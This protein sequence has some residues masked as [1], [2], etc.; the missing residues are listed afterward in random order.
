[1]L[2][3]LRRFDLRRIPQ[4]G[5]LAGVDE[6]GRVALAGP[7]V[8]ACVFVEREELGR[9]EFSR[10]WAGVNDSKQLTAAR[11]ETL[12]RLVE[13][14]RE[15]GRLIGASGSASVAEIEARNI[16]GATRMAMRRALEAACPERWALPVP[17]TGGLFAGLETISGGRILIDGKPL[18]PFPYEHD[19]V[20]K[21]DGKSF[22]IALASILAKVT[23]DHL[24]EDLDQ[25]YPQYGFREHKGY[26]T[27]AHRAAI[28]EHGPSPVH[29][30]LFLRKLM[31][32]VP[33]GKPETDD[34]FAEA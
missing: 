31:A 30:P 14:E 22:A 15:A 13:A 11:R 10:R 9:A 20:V 19:A 25:L 4:G 2:E 18:R 6:A 1:M 24:M 21:G 17:E 3:S 23:R 26:G 32:S 16:L 29:R 5:W 33:A 8:A 27:A 7:V 28:L 12:F 34:L